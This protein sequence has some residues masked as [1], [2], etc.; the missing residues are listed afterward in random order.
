MMAVADLSLADLFDADVV[1]RLRQRFGG[2]SITIPARA[3][4][5]HPIRAIAG[6]DSFER[7]V[8]LAGG[9]RLYVP[10]PSRLGAR[11]R[12]VAR[13]RRRGL[14]VALIARRVRL[15]ERRI[16]QILRTEKIS[17]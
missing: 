13:L 11:N 10:Q 3:H 1:A 7:A 14:P 8:S 4:I 9:T 16:Y 17:G 2:R 15:S 5:T 12:T 6:D